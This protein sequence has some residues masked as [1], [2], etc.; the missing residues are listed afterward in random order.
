MW[1]TAGEPGQGR[2]A[3]KANRG[4]AGTKV[5][6]NFAGGLC[7]TMNQPDRYIFKTR[8]HGIS[9]QIARLG[10]YPKFEWKSGD[11]INDM[12]QN[13]KLDW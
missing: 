1:Q 7:G 6:Q 3:S 13:T 10:G 12:Y 5:Q 8:L 11:V 2:E 9:L 4:A